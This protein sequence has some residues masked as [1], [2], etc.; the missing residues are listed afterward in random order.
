MP[1]A[2]P[3]ALVVALIAAVAC[4]SFAPPSRG[5]ERSTGGLDGFRALLNDAVAHPPGRDRSDDDSVRSRDDDRV[6]GD[7]GGAGDRR[8]EVDDDDALNKRG[9]DVRATGRGATTTDPGSGDNPDDRDPD[10]GGQHGG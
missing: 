5:A 9:P 7:G 3:R 4:A 2:A 10:A 1:A 6:Q 8:A